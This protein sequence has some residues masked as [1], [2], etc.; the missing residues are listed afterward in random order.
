MSG[1]VSLTVNQ[2]LVFFIF[3]L[4][5]Y[6]FKK[7]GLIN[8][9]LSTVISRLEVSVFMPALC[10]NTF[11]VNFNLAVLKEKSVFLLA[12]TL[13]LGITFL[14]AL[15]LSNAFT[16][17]PMTRGIYIYALAVPNFGYMGFPLILAVYGEQMLLNFMIVGIPYNIFI[18]TVGRNIFSGDKRFSPRNMLDPTLIGIIIGAVA[19]LTG[20]RLPV[21]LGNTLTIAAACL[22][23]LAMIMTGFILARTPFKFNI[24]NPKIYL[25]S[26]LR[27]L[28]IPLTAGAILL[29]LHV[30]LEVV[31]TMTAFLCMPMGLNNVI[32]PE[33][34]G[35][36]SGTGAQCCFVSQVLGIFTIPA[37][38]ALMGLWG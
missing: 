5:G 9:S 19:G 20:L 8:D 26:A 38:F 27:L 3:M 4:C 17:K 10:F 1:I 36:D 12:G 13:T 37:V 28:I 35:G 11:S 16:K 32:F 7:K 34:Y 22:A 15:F 14:L 30:R 29:L 2:I 6:V 21:F 25:T 18:Y 24:S 31:L 23:P 33:A